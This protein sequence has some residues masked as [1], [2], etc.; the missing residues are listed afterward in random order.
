MFHTLFQ[1]ANDGMILHGTQGRILEVNPK[2]LNL[3]GYTRDELLNRSFGKLCFTN[4]LPV[5][6]RA[7]ETLQRF[8]SANFELLLE[9]N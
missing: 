7:F 1:H 2:G 6:A 8:G 9:Q 3:L 4:N 5:A